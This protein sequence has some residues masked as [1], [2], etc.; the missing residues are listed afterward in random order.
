MIAN[1]GFS[2]RFPILRISSLVQPSLSS[3]QRSYLL[4]ARRPGGKVTEPGRWVSNDQLSCPTSG[5]PVPDQA[6]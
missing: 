3:V 2:S 1:R 6:K 5:L 4:G